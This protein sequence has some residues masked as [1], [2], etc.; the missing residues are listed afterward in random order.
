V[1]FESERRGSAAEG[2]ER[3]K[4]TPEYEVKCSAGGSARGSAPRSQSTTPWKRQSMPAFFTNAVSKE[5]EDGGENG[6]SKVANVGA[7]VLEQ[8][9]L[10]CV[11]ITCRLPMRKQ[12]IESR[13]VRSRWGGWCQWQGG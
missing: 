12:R 3:M 1:R 5:K 9:R 4:K 6:R 13:A 10:Q 2:W 11:S 8:V 7:D